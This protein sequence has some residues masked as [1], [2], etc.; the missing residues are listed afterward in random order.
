MKFGKKIAGLLSHTYN[1][2][3]IADRKWIF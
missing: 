2:H 1:V 3:K